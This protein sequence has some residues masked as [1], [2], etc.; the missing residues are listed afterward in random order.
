MSDP[1][2]PKMVDALAGFLGI[3]RSLASDALERVWEE[4]KDVRSGAPPSW[5]PDLSDPG[6]ALARRVQGA[7]EREFDGEPLFRAIVVVEEPV[8]RRVGIAATAMNWGDV[9]ELLMLGRGAAK[10]TVRQYG[11]G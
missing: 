1:I 3:S 4:T 10:R 2:R 5:Q 9:D 6:Q 11:L 7:L 8:S